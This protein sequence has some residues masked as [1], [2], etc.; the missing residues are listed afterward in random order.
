MGVPGSHG[1]GVS[2]LQ[3]GGGLAGGQFWG[4]FTP[5]LWWPGWVPPALAPPR[6][7]V[8]S[9]QN[10]VP[11]HRLWESPNKS[12]V[13][14]GESNRGGNSGRSFW[15]QG[16]GTAE[17]ARVPLG[18]LGTGPPTGDTGGWRGLL[19]LN[20]LA[21]LR[22]AQQTLPASHPEH[23]GLSLRGTRDGGATVASQSCSERAADQGSRGLWSMP[24][25]DPPPSAQG[26]AFAPLRAVPR[27]LCAAVQWRR[28]GS[29][30]A[31]G[32]VFF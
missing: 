18:W 11:S 25:S 5:L 26:V 27:A 9:Q 32:H 7:A 8:T 3:A 31:G 16:L 13:S 12:K 19:W 23:R 28:Q 15:D 30:G 20:L 24:P 17:F 2:W 10:P 14:A 21:R 1:A 22:C 6:D 4:I 29:A